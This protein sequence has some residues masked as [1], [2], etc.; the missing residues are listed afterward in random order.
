MLGLCRKNTFLRFHLLV[1]RQVED[2][3]GR[4]MRASSNENLSFTQIGANLSS[5]V[6]GQQRVPEEGRV[7]G[8]CQC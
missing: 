1:F 2:R 7:Y 3:M 8:E 4:R 5:V 6:P